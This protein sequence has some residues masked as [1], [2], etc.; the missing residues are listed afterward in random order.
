[1]DRKALRKAFKAGAALPVAALAEL[2]T[3][4]PETGSMVW[5]ERGP[6]WAVSDR[7]A[8]IFNEQ[9]AG[10]PA[11]QASRPGSGSSPAGKLFGRMIMASH[12]AYALAYGEWPDEGVHFFNGNREDFR[13]E[14]MGPI[15]YSD[16]GHLRVLSAGPGK[17]GLPVGISMHESGRFRVRQCGKLLGYADTLEDAE[18]IRKGGLMAKGLA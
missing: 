11:L 9:F 18:R 1:M 10:K 6:E 2:V 14:N 17:S 4:D 8:E 16:M 12:A 15:S 3:Y 7:R 13:K 5:A